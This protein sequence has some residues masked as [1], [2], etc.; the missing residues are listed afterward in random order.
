VKVAESVGPIF[1]E[2]NYRFAIK[3]RESKKLIFIRLPMF[4]QSINLT[5]E[6]QVSHDLLQ[7][8]ILVLKCLSIDS[9]RSNSYITRT[10]VK[11]CTYKLCAG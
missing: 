5:I 1:T 6:R 2:I 7:L 3:A 11:N 9:A 4:D 10:V 8:R